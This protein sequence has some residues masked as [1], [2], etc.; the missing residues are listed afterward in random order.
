MPPAHITPTAP[1]LFPSLWRSTQVPPAAVRPA[2]HAHAPLTQTWRGAHW[3][4]IAPQLFGSVAVE[5]QRPPA[6]TDPGGH[7]HV[8]DVHVC[9][10]L[11]C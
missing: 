11:H 5:M 10:R 2:G 1:Q 4:P 3:V 6:S 7:E 9:P 8:P